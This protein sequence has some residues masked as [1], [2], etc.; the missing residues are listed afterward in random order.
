MIFGTTELKPHASKN[1]AEEDKLVKHMMTAV[2]QFTKDP[3]RG[4]K[5]LGYPMYEAT[6]KTLIR[7][8]YQNKSENNFG[9]STEYDSQCKL[10]KI[11]KDPKSPE[12]MEELSKAIEGIA[13]LMEGLGKGA[14]KAAAKGA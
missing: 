3:E 5:R 4:L 1:T 8:G 2:A 7:W 9:T 13:G 14:P 6:G 12:S 10:I 11:I